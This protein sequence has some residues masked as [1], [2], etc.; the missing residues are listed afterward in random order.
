MT[1]D[2][3]KN[4]LKSIKAMA[5]HSSMTS[6]LKTGADVLIKAYNDIYKYAVEQDW[7]DVNI[8]IV[9]AINSDEIPKDVKKMDCVGVSAGLLINFIEAKKDDE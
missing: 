9:G 4:L 5:E 7:I 6:A 1:I 3:A 8:G 2:K